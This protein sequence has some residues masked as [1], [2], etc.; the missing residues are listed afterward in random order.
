MKANMLA[1]GRLY[2]SNKKIYFYA[3]I[4][5]KEI[6]VKLHTI[7]MFLKSLLEE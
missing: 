3:N 6:K 7:V 1:Q 2:I 4:L 5:G